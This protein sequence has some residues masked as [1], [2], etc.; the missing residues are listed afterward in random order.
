MKFP[1]KQIQTSDFKKQSQLNQIIFQQPINMIVIKI[2][3]DKIL[4]SPYFD[5]P[6]A[7]E[8]DHYISLIN[9]KNNEVVQ[10]LEAHK[11]RVTTVRHFQDPETKN[12]Y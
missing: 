3:I 12:N 5:L 7:V 9:L 11:D 8:R 2:K 10:N 6:K 4:I 1:S